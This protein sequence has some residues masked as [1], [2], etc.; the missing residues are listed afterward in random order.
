MKKATVDTAAKINIFLDIAGRLE[1]GYHSLFMLM[2]SVSLFD[3]VSLEQAESG[4]SLTCSEPRLPADN[5][6]IAYKAAAAFFDFTKINS[7]I[8]IHIEKRI[9]FEAGLAGG[10][11][12]AAAVIA[13]LNRLFETGLK[14]EELFRLGLKIGS[15]VPFCIAGGTKLVQHTGGVISPMPPLRPC[16]IVIAKPVCGVSTKA[17]YDTFD[18]GGYIYRPNTVKF[19]E[20]AANGCFEGICRHAVNVFEQV[21]EVPQRVE[22]KAIMR[23]H[24]AALIQMSGSGPSIFGLFDSPE[25]AELSAA[26]LRGFIDE[27]FVCEPTAKSIVYSDE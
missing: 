25:N 20:A 9:P 10:S 13:G 15:D 11:A 7:G 17:A 8:R 27:V 23:K 5:S 18:N 3:S 12:D 22:I 21:I 6:N 24:R 14:Q 26:E 1:S 16:S 19:L 4:I 2:Q